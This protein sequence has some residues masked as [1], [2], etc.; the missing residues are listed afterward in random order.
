MQLNML[1]EVSEGNV[2]GVMKAV[3]L[4]SSLLRLG[5]EEELCSGGVVGG[6]GRTECCRDVDEPT[7]FAR[8]GP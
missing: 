1:G 8:P 2:D 3:V 6:G 4:F 5:W 7:D